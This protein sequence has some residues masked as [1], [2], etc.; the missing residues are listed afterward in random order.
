MTLIA[1]AAHEKSADLLTDTASYTPGIRRMGHT[2]KVTPIAHIDAALMTQGDSRFGYVMSNVVHDLAN[3]APDLDAL[4]GDLPGKARELWPV[5]SAGAPDGWDVA[6]FLVG[7]SPA[8]GRFVARGLA[9]DTNFE[10]WDIDGLHVMPS[11]ITTRP[12]DL[13]LGR[14]AKAGVSPEDVDR[15]RQMPIPAVPANSAQWLKLGLEARIQR[16]GIPGKLKVVVAGHLVHTHLSRG[17]VSSKRIHTFDDAG[18]EFQK[19]V[20]G[21]LHPQGQLGPCPCD[22]GKRFLDC[23]LAKHA[24]ELCLCKSG[25]AFGECCSVTQNQRASAAADPSSSGVDVPC[26]PATQLLAP[27]A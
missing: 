26:P 15:L 4:L 13:E 17:K 12:S 5:M 14:A 16:F 21:T 1:F 20:A 24:T 27:P 7:Y 9:S 3:L 23:H 6:A 11:P 19:M 2:T 22:S 18:P 25:K 10:P 8:A